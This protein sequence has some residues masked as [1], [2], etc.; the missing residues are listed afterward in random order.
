MYQRITITGDPESGKSY[1]IS[2]YINDYGTNH[3]ISP[4]ISTRTYVPTI[5]VDF[6]STIVVINVIQP[7]KLQIWDTSGKEK[8]KIV[9]RCYYRD[10]DI[11]MITFDL[12]SQESFYNVPK[13]YNEIRAVNKEAKICMIGCKDDLH[14]VVSNDD[15]YTLSKGLNIPFYKCS[16]LDPS[17]VKH[18]F[19]TVIN[20]KLQMNLKD[21]IQVHNSDLPLPPKC[22]EIL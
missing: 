14:S 18:V 11:I 15:A 4:Y 16:A 7:V 2:R 3:T 13:W 10:A 5:C 19:E 8:Y 21:L 6:Y 20:S 17:S 9:T 1:L 22:C 12:A